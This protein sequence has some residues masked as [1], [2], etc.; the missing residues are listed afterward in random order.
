[1]ISLFKVGG[2]Q[3]RPARPLP[4]KLQTLLDSANDGAVLVSFGSSLRS[5]SL[6]M[7]IIMVIIMIITI[8]IFPI[9]VRAEHMAPHMVEMFLDVFRALKL[10]VIWR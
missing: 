10:L 1:M 2:L 5:S 8:M 6:F 9:M 4:S 3:L 7:I